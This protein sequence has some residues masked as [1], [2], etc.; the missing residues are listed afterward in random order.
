MDS[1]LICPLKGWLG[2]EYFSWLLWKDWL[3]VHMCSL[4]IKCN[5]LPSMQEMDCLIQMRQRLSYSKIKAQLSPRGHVIA[6][7]IVNCACLYTLPS[8]RFGVL[9][10]N[11]SNVRIIFTAKMRVFCRIPGWNSALFYTEVF[12]MWIGN[13][14]WSR[15]LRRTEI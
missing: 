15:L 14:H 12:Y 6:F 3:S 13:C 5:I 10:W 2:E 9:R 1:K 7:I 4:N 8:F 11:I